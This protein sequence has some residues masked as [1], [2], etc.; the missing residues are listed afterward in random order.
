MVSTS[1]STLA[2]ERP[3]AAATRAACAR[4]LATEMSGSRPL[5]EVVTMSIGTCA[6]PQAGLAFDGCVDGRPHL[7]R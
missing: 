4:A 7:V 3:R 1:A 5:P 6:A 2:A